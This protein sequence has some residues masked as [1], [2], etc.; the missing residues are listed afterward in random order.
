MSSKRRRPSV[1]IVDRERRFYS[2]A[3]IDDLLAESNRSPGRA[4]SVKVAYGEGRP[5]TERWM[6]RELFTHQIDS[7]ACRYVLF[8]G[9]Q[10]KPAD[11]AQRKA[12]RAMKVAAG[13]L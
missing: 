6:I 13:R 10:D 11:P 3:Q 1:T 7:V 5:K 12:I 9:G 2:G 4:I 8:K